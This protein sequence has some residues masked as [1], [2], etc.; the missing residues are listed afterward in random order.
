MA[1]WGVT[2]DDFPISVER[3]ERPL[4]ESA[5]AV[6]DEMLGCGAGRD[7][8]RLLAGSALCPQPH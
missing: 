4:A 2:R 3:S 6:R 1:S 7:E 8:A 5:A